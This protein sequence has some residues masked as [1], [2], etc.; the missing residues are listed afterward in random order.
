MLAKTNVPSRQGQKEGWQSLE[1]TSFLRGCKFGERSNQCLPLRSLDDRFIARELAIECHPYSREPD[2][3]MEP[4]SAQLDFEEQAD[5]IVAPFC[6]GHF[7]K[8]H[9]IN[10]CRLSN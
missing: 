3:R 4:Q 5:Q 9:S 2:E 1:E 8:Q 7:V 6:V 10:S